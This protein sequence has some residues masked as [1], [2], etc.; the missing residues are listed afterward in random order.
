MTIEE[1]KHHSRKAR[2]TRTKS[3]SGGDNGSPLTVLHSATS[4]KMAVAAGIL[5]VALWS[6]QE[7]SALSFEEG[8]PNESFAYYNEAVWQPDYGYP[9]YNYYTY[10]TSTSTTYDS[11]TNYTSSVDVSY[12]STFT[13]PTYTNT[14]TN[15]YPMGQCTWGVKVL[16]PWVGDYW[17]NAADWVASAQA[18]GYQVGTTPQ[19]GAVAVWFDGGYGHVAYVVDVQSDTAI[20]VLES[21]YNGIMQIGNYRGIFDP[22]DPAYGYS[23]MYIYPAS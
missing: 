17:G 14:E 21:N 6:N 8:A 22:T 20:Q 5:G 13:I 23:V 3:N 10:D 11:S 19:E 15:T 16:A 1:S 7:A 12:D 2:T 4:L 9:A 18:A